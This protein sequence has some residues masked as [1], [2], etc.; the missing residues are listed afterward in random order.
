YSGAPAGTC[1]GFVACFDATTRERGDGPRRRP[2]R[3]VGPEQ[4]TNPW[5][6]EPVGAA[7]DRADGRHGL[8]A[9]GGRRTRGTRG[10]VNPW[11]RRRTAPT[12]GTGCR[13]RAADEP[14][15]R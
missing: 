4:P 14:V 13:P 5:H 10:T 8:S 6:G 7:T 12:V 3:V 11:G 1:H 2:A 9:P 15:A